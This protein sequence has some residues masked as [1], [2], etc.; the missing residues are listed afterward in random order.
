[1]FIVLSL[2]VGASRVCA[3]CRTAADLRQRYSIYTYTVHVLSL[4]CLLTCSYCNC[5]HEKILKD[6]LFYF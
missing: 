2:S 3:A 4:Y 6:K 1:M 5:Q